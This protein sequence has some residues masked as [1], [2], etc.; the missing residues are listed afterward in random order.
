MTK[1]VHYCSLHT[2][3]INGGVILSDSQVVNKQD[4]SLFMEIDCVSVNE[5]IEAIKSYCRFDVYEDGQTCIDAQSFCDAFFHVTIYNSQ[6][7]DIGYIVKI[8]LNDVVEVYSKS[9]C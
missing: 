6:F 1:Y 3:G 2:G 7:R 4:Y 5:I 8:H 9:I